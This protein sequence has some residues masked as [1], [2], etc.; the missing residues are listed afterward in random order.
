M[1]S[2]ALSLGI[3]AA[4]IVGSRFLLIVLCRALNDYETA[5]IKREWEEDTWRQI[6]KAHANAPR[7]VRARHLDA[8]D[9]MDEPR[10]V[11]ARNITIPHAG[12]Y[13]EEAQ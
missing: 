3:S 1:T 9:F 10:L 12:P 6:Q 4:A 2:I 11:A 8:D 13:A 7:D 5:R